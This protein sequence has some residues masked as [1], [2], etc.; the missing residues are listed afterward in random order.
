MPKQKLNIL[1]SGGGTGGHI[2]PALAIAEAIKA[3]HPDADFL[4]VG[5]RGRMEMEKV[6][7]AGYKIKGLWISGLQRK[8]S[9][10]NLVFP[11]KVLSSLISAGR[12]IRK[13][14][15]DIAIGVGGY[16]SAPAL[17]MASRKGIPTLIQEQN[18]F[19]GIANKVL[20]GRVE[21]ICVAY[22]GME[23]YFP[24]DKI[25]ITGNPVRRTAMP[26]ENKKAEAAKHFGLAP[27]KATVLITGGSLGAR[28]LNET[29]A[30][31]LEQLLN[32]GLQIIWQTGKSFTAEAKGITEKYTDAGLHI[33]TFIQRMD[34]AYSIADLVVS[35]AGAIAIA[36]MS[37]AAKACIL[38]PSPNVAE[39][40]QT[41]NA[42]A[43]E[44]K[45][46]AVMVRD[47]DAMEQL[48]GAI[49]HLMD[50]PE[51]RRILENNIRGLAK[52][53][54]D[55]EIAGIAMDLINR[56]TKA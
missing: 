6:P 52:P 36:E 33:A 26:S 49:I 30:G 9:L 17:F 7:A 39:D 27:D 37:A 3:M 28:T 45:N 29:M 40:H 24:A 50:N 8:L 43:L 4:F 55:R 34:L 47:Q 46:A 20:S 22:E 19:P 56:K 44:Q 12:I 14:R 42:R 21:A 38:V 48:T 51:E 35:R 13:F 23:K 10:K 31:G 2:F 11:F 18:A 1:I 53:D 5:A 41:K 15:P 54:A 32:K 25:H 16:A